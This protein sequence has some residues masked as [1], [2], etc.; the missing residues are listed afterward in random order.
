MPEH[1][2]CPYCGEPIDSFAIALAEGEID[3][4]TTESGRKIVRK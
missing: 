1:V 4:S 3:T 2:D